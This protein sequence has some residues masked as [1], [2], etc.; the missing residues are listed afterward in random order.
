MKQPKDFE[1]L[2]NNFLSSITPEDDAIVLERERREKEEVLRINHRET[3]PERF[4]R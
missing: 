4:F 2:I 3:V 1:T